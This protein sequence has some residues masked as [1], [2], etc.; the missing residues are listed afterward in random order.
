M[1]PQRLPPV[2]APLLAAMA[3]AASPT[4]A[5]ADGDRWQPQVAV[6]LD[7]PQLDNW[8]ARVNFGG[9]VA[10]DGRLKLDPGHAVGLEL[11]L[12][13]GR[14]RLALEGQR[15]QLD[16]TAVE[17]GTQ[18]GPATGR[19]RY[20]A[21]TVNA[22]WQQP[23]TENASAEALIGIGRGRV[24][25]PQAALASGG[26]NCFAAAQASGTVVQARL[27]LSWK[28][29]RHHEPFVHLGSLRLPGAQGQSGTGPAVTYPRRSVVQA[30]LG[31]RV[32][33]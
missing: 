12:Q 3:L 18:A 9:G 30:G 21:V 25:L 19:V 1:T 5:A 29:D 13:R 26:C 17:L 7:R 6:H 31:V 33:F 10:L 20:Q 14:V 15:G 27:G 28:L 11:A 24:E 4:L 23:L 8:P 22:A 32:R 16:L 2:A